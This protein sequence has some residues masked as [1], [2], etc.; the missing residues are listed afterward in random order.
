MPNNA[1]LALGVSQ[2]ATSDFA[3]LAKVEN[4]GSWPLEPSCDPHNSDV[5]GH[6]ITPQNIGVNAA[7]FD[8]SN[9][10]PPRKEIS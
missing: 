6:R 3:W 2:N 10:T 4:H 5:W 1:P 9:V 8:A 7:T